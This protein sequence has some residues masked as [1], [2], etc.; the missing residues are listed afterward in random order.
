MM[1][2]SLRIKRGKGPR[3]ALTNLVARLGRSNEKIT[4]HRVSF[5]VFL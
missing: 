3:L 5:L 4:K 1:L 2:T